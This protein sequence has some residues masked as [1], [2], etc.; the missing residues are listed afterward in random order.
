VFE[1]VLVR[2]CTGDACLRAKVRP[3]VIQY[4]F[5]GGFE[6]TSEPRPLTDKDRIFVQVQGVRPG[7]S[8]GASIDS[9]SVVQRSIGLAGLPPPANVQFQF[10]D[11][12]NSSIFGFGSVNPLAV[13]VQAPSTQIVALG[14]LAGGN[15]YAFQVCASSSTSDDCTV[16]LPQAPGGGSQAPATPARTPTAPAPTAPAA[17]GA[18]AAGAKSPAAPD[19]VPVVHREI[20][21]NTLIV[22]SS[23][24]LGVRAGFG[25]SET[26]SYGN[27]RDLV[28]V[29]GTSSSAVRE[30]DHITD[31]GLPLLLAY[32]P[33]PRDAVDLPSGVSLGIV[34]GLDALHITNPRLYL[35]LAI[36]V[37]GL[38]FTL[39]GSVQS[40]STVNDSTGTVVTA[41]SVQ[42]DTV[43]L[44]GV[45]AGITTDLDI[46]EAV[47]GK[48]F[49]TTASLPSI[50][51]PGGS[52]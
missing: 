30:V 26:N 48:F 28:P 27:Y 12:T 11:Q 4:D 8:I 44:P 29:P 3:Y 41:S 47:Y 36:D 6:R 38:G 49:S 21:L 9:K 20:A 24:R 7:F 23:V 31:F 18:P 52:K 13:D 22:H 17:G 46:F 39:A 50:T 42:R 34:G 25:V 32:Y 33:C 43:W 1:D 15:R 2:G 35:G 16:Q 19:A 51:P 5:S 45:F 40:L 37:W 14:S 10:S